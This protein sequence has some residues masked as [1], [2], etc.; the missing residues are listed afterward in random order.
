MSELLIPADPEVAARTELLAG[1]QGTRFASV[2]VGTKLPTAD[3]KPPQ[4]VR[5]TTAGGG[6][7]DLVTD[8]PLLVLDGFAVREQDA[9][10]LTA[11]ALGLLL[12][13]GRSGEL[14]GVTC[15]GV[16]VGGLP[17]N[18]P[19]PAVP[20]HFRFTATASADLRRTTV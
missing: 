10:D 7:R 4:F 16:A 18:L 5:V 20:T 17:A 13:A 2:A 8:R 6:E 1:F 11:L 14:G 12:R 19:H 15:Y 3:P 9:R